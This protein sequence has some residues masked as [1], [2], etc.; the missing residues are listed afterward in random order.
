M[1]GEFLVIHTHCIYGTLTNRNRFPCKR[2][3]WYPTASEKVPGERNQVPRKLVSFSQ[4]Q[5][6]H[7]HTRTYA[8]AHTHTHMDTPMLTHTHTIQNKM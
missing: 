4:T 1:E 8:G 6:T 5:R 7:T 2:E 3:V